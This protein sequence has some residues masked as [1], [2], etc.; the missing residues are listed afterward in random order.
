MFLGKVKLLISC[1][2]CLVLDK[3]WSKLGFSSPKFVQI[4]VFFFMV[5]ML[6][7]RKKK[8]KDPTHGRHSSLIGVNEQ[9]FVS[10]LGPKWLTMR[11]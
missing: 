11:Q 3:N 6:K 2:N 4:S 10:V 8:N 5:K 9:R 7:K 1:P